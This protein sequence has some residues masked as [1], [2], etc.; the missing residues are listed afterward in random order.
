MSATTYKNSKNI[1]VGKFYTQL[2]TIYNSA[3]ED[4]P[5]VEKKVRSIYNQAIPDSQRDPYDNSDANMTNTLYNN[6]EMY[7]SQLADD[8]RGLKY[9]VE[10]SKQKNYDIHLK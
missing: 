3:R 9:N 8:E 7:T 2:D 10:K 1:N 6:R 5:K 4:N